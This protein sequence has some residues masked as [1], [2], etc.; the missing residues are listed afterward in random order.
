MYWLGIEAMD[1]IGRRAGQCVVSEWLDLVFIEFQLPHK[2]NRP[3]PPPDEEILQRFGAA[4]LGGM[5]QRAMALAGD[6]G[7]E[8][9]SEA[10]IGKALREGAQ[11]GFRHNLERERERQKAR[12]ALLAR[13][14]R[15]EG[16]TKGR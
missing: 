2:I 10:R 13:L 6:P 5:V 7:R 4:M 11:A 3:D 14:E 1:A 8:K 9:L 12:G 16:A 15:G